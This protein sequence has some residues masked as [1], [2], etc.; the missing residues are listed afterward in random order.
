MEQF[1]SAIIFNRREE[2]EVLLRQ[3]R[4]VSVLEDQSGNSIL[5]FLVQFKAVEMLARALEHFESSGAERD[6]LASWVNRRNSRGYSP[7][8]YAVAADEVKALKLLTERE[9]DLSA[10]FGGQNSLVHIA[11]QEDSLAS[12]IFLSDRVSLDSPNSS[13]MTPLMLAAWNDNELSLRYLLSLRVSLNSRE[14]AGNSALHIAVSRGHL[15]NA[16]FLLSAGA[17]PAARNRAG[18]TPAQLAKDM[19]AVAMRGLF[20]PASLRRWLANARLSVPQM[21]ERTKLRMAQTLLPANLFLLLCLLAPRR[22]NRPSRPRVPLRG[23]YR[24]R[25]GLRALCRGPVLE[26]RGPTSSPRLAARSGGPRARERL[27]NLL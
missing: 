1:K 12:L 13:M 8:Y 23:P 27:Q 16:F 9:A 25:P 26:P 2:F 11:A 3:S 14:S 17:N 15:K 19:R 4:D 7:I 21:R 22:L 5:V 6:V 20:E 24:L 10:T 18:I